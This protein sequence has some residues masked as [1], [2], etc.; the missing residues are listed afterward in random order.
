ME[1]VS[2]IWTWIGISLGGVSLAGIIVAIIYGSLK[3]AFNRTIRKVNVEKI[4]ER[5]CDKSI[6]RIK[7][8]SFTQNI[9]PIVESELKKITEEANKYIDKNLK[10]T[11]EK[12]DQLIAILEKFYAYFDDSLVSDAKKQELKKAI[13]QAKMAKPQLSK[14]FGIKEIVIESQKDKEQKKV[15]LVKPQDKIKIER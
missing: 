2:N 7:E 13:E 11:Q 14:E 3:G 9:Q 15:V 4:A 12:Y 1:F 10:D 6:D 5:V 8:V